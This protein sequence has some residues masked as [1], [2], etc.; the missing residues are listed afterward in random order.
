MFQKLDIQS[1]ITPSLGLA[2]I[3]FLELHFVYLLSRVLGG[4]KDFVEIF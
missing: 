3:V 4:S 1:D 2:N